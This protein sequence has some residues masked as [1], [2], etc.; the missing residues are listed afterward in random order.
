MDLKVRPY[1][2]DG[3][4]DPSDRRSVFQLSEEEL[5]GGVERGQV[6]DLVAVAGDVDDLPAA[7]TDPVGVGLRPLDDELPT[8]PVGFHLPVGHPPFYPQVL[9]QQDVGLQV[10][11]PYSPAAECFRHKNTTPCPGRNGAPVA[12]A[13]S[14]PSRPRAGQVSVY[15]VTGSAPN[16]AGSG[17]SFG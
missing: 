3:S 4:L 5:A 15:L 8:T 12:P 11:T 9:Y 6:G 16:S 7:V 10:S 2:R 13:S 17:S 1:S 14:L